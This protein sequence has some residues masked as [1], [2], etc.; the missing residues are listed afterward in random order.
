MEKQI[1]Q[2][3]NQEARTKIRKSIKPGDPSSLWK[4]V[5]NASGPEINDFPEEMYLDGAEIT[6]DEDKADV[7][8]YFFENKIS[9]ITNEVK[10]KE[11]E[12]TGTNHQNLPYKNVLSVTE[13]IV[14]KLLS[15]T[16]PKNSC[17]YDRIP[18]R[19][20]TECKNSLTE[21]ITSLINK[22]LKTGEIP[23]Q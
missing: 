21:T 20:L 14:M 4:A 1:R 17:G 15:E 18:M 19:V 13:D 6:E 22:I 9:K 11:N 3:I 23:S 10:C 5:K 8:K 7:F 16:S 2:T 12:Y